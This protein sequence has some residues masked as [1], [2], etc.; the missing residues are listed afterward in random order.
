MRVGPPAPADA[1]AG[2][3]VEPPAKRCRH[4]GAESR[5]HDDRCPNCGRSY[6]SGPWVIVAA[7][8]AA[9]ISAILLLGG[10]AALIAVGL[11][12]A[13]DEIDERAITRA[14]FDSV[15]PG[16]SEA[17]VRAELGKPLSEDSYRKRG[18][19]CLGY[20]EKDEGLFGIDEFELCFRNG[21]L[22]SKSAG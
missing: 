20:A 9:V 7:I 3:P 19:T 14:Q 18:L 1:A 5:T 13:E 21:V 2:K 11:D 4:C 17:S 22:V 12:A 16:D 6:G 15:K 10:C 8:V